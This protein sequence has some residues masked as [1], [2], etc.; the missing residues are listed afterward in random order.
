[1]TDQQDLNTAVASRMARQAVLY[2][3]VRTVQL[4]VGEAALRWPIDSVATLVAQLD[5]LALFAADGTVRFGIVPFDRPFGAFSYHGWSVMAE[6]DEEE[7]DLVHIELETA[8]VDITDPEQTAA[9]RDAFERLWD[10]ALVGEDAAQLI[11][12]IRRELSDEGGASAQR[13]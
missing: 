3:P 5:R 4:L 10:L 12:R 13:W 9:Y 1:M 2:D 11:R 7:S 8:T 6:R